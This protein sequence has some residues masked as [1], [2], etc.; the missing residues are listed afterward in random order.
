MDP[1]HNIILALTPN[2]KRYFKMFAKTF[3]SSGQVMRLFEELNKMSLYD[4]RVLAKKT[5][6]KNLIAAKISLR[7]FLFRAMR[8]YREDVDIQQQL[9]DDISN[10]EFLVRKNLNEEAA[11]EIRKA[12]KVAEKGEVYSS[13]SELLIYSAI[14]ETT[15][16]K[17]EEVRNYFM[18]VLAHNKETLKLQGEVEQAILYQRYMTYSMRHGNYESPDELSSQ[19]RLIASE[20][21]QLIPLTNSNYAKICLLIALASHHGRDQSLDIY[22]QIHKLYK[23]EPHNIDKHTNLYFSFLTNYITLTANRKEFGR[24][25]PQLFDEIEKGFITYKSYFR[26]YPDKLPFFRNRL[27]GN[28][29]TYC[30]L[31]NQWGEM[32]SLIAAVKESITHRA[33]RKELICAM[34][35][36]SLIGA[37]FCQK[38]YS[39]TTDWI[40]IY[41]TLPSAKTMKPLMLCVRFI[42]CICFHQLGNYELSDSKSKNLI[43]TFGEMQLNDEYHKLLIV[44]L[45]RLNHWLIPA[46]GHNTE[47]SE[48]RQ[49]FEKLRDD[50]DSY[51]VLYSAFLEPDKALA[52]INSK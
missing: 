42:E 23:Q 35:V 21:E 10:I 39:D 52:Q 30:K 38:R 48:L 15:V 24:F 8:N 11:K 12:I 1:L 14:V 20:I 13:L 7:K 33:Y 29:L 5:G 26:Y 36:G 4:E 32:D 41:Y 17:G 37:V 25:V 16:I 31:N 51:Y 3:K 6:I 47:I 22:Q 28:K 49:K 18:S 45:R 27:I 46:K 44:V 19:M 2:E 40:H 43:K 50:D 9:R 34:V